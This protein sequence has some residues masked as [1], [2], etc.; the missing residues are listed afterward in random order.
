MNIGNNRIFETPVIKK[1]GDDI[2]LSE[3]KTGKIKFTNI[4]IDRSR[5]SITEIYVELIDYLIE[6]KLTIA[7]QFLFGTEEHEFQNRKNA[8][9]YF[10]NLNW[11]V[12]FIKQESY[13]GSYV[14]GTIISAIS[15]ENIKPILEKE[16]VIG[17]FFEDE[18]AGYLFFG[19]LMPDTPGQSNIQQSEQSFKMLDVSL[20]KVGMDIGNVARTWFYLNDLLNWYDDFN[21]VRNNY[22]TIKG[23]FE[24]MVPASTG[25]GA[26]NLRSSSLLL[27]GYAL[28]KKQN[29]IKTKAV[30]SPF[31]CPASDYKSSFSRAVE[32][33]HPDYR[34]LIVS[35]TASITSEGKT[36][37][38]GSISKQ[39]ELTMK[40][41]YGIL[42]SREMT[43]EN[44]TRGIIYFKNINDIN[45]FENYCSDNH[46]PELPLSMIKADICRN[47]LL[48]EIEVDAITIYKN[49]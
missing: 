9:K 28:K 26:G 23:V 17:N 20:N 44:V 29:S 19:G 6:N 21:S 15:V 22:F 40:V 32:I 35:G 2:L 18:F 37:N 38:I 10:K 4:A 39:I 5:K 13:N 47:D 45:S 36:A 46:I 27:G 3:Y 34:H 42:Q 31:Q 14:W 8:E 41:V 30:E 12:T 48:F 1:I 16:T 43:W 11:P 33:N 24:G 25:I 49:N 7:N